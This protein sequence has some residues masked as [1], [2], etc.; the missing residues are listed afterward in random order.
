MENYINLIDQKKELQKRLNNLMARQFGAQSVGEMDEIS[1]ER[2]DIN[3]AL[4]IIN[5]K[6]TK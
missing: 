5:E 1:R 4:K 2:R 3:A 6:L